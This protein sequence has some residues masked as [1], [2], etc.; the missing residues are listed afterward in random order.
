MDTPLLAR[1]SST[2]HRLCISRPQRDHESAFVTA[3]RTVMARTQGRPAIRDL[4]DLGE[5]W[6]TDE[7]SLSASAEV[8]VRYEPSR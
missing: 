1:R 3:M 8:L 6:A 5:Y 4:M 2:A 7:V